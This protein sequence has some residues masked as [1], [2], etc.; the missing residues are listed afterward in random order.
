VNF[1][2]QCSPQQRL[3][4]PESSSPRVLAQC[5]WWVAISLKQ[6][7]PGWQDFIGPLCTETTWIGSPAQGPTGQGSACGRLWTRCT[8]DAPWDLV[9]ARTTGSPLTSEFYSR[10]VQMFCTVQTSR[11]R[12]LKSSCVERD[13]LLNVGQEKLEPRYR[14]AFSH[15]P[16]PPLHKKKETSFVGCSCFMLPDCS[17]LNLWYLTLSRCNIYTFVFYLFMT[18]SDL[19]TAFTLGGR[20]YILGEINNHITY[21]PPPI[22]RDSRV[23]LM[24]YEFSP[25]H[26][27]AWMMPNERLETSA[28]QQWR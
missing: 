14:S 3:E 23:P 12:T 13:L 17:L 6:Q 9:V 25:L 8:D 10:S 16:N 15:R 5:Y 27:Y 21:P 20:V 1:I 24:K 26:L 28:L 2:W 11:S 19:T 7:D 18:M 4:A 22:C